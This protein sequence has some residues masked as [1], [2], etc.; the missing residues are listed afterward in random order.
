MDKPTREELLE[1]LRELVYK[2]KGQE[3]RGVQMKRADWHRA[4]ALVKQSEQD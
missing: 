1:A 2:W 3:D 4:K